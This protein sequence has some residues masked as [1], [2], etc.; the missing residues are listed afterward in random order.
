MSNTMHYKGYTASMNFDTVDQVIV[1][2]VL[3]IDDIIAFHGESVAEFQSHFH[4]AIDA[5]SPAQ[6]LAHRSN[7][8]ASTTPTNTAATKS[9]STVSA[10]V[11]SSTSTSVRE[12][13]RAM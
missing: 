9:T 10:K 12:G 13:P 8:T 2:R 11:T 3:D 5:L 1:G 6:P 7:P 4:A